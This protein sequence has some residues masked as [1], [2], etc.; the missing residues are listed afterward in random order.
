M[1]RSL[2][3]ALLGAGTALA[4]ASAGRFDASETFIRVWDLRSGQTRILDLGDG[5]TP[6][7][8]RFT[9]DGGLISVSGGHVHRWDPQDGTHEIMLEGDDEITA[10][11][12]ATRLDTIGY[13]VVCDIESRVTRRCI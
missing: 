8:L 12:C 7:R 10:Q 1:L 5:D 13:E 4:A 11:E 9:P 6:G 3:I 2:A